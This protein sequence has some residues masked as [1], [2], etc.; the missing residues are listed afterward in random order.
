MNEDDIQKLVENEFTS[1]ATARVYTEAMSSEE[2]EEKSFVENHHTSI[3]GSLS[4]DWSFIACTTK[5]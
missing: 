4:A 2:E 5:M 3:I 1:R